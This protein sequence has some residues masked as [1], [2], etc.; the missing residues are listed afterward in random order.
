MPP[1]YPLG[2]RI[3]GVVRYADIRVRDRRARNAP[4]RLRRKLV[5]R[6]LCAKL[7]TQR[8]AIHTTVM[9]GHAV[10]SSLLKPSLNYRK[11]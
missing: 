2:R 7:I 10:S 8:N 3:S 4:A 1:V 11:Q 6:K 5:A 9:T